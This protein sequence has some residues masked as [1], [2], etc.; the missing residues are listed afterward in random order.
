M[1]PLAINF[2]L[3]NKYDEEENNN[4]ECFCCDIC[5]QSIN[6]A[7]STEEDTNNSS[8]ILLLANGKIIHEKCTENGQ[9][10]TQIF[11][12]CYP[13]RISQLLKL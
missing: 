6:D 11:P 1:K 2:E 12:K 13:E 4:N 10:P 5:N 3:L 8:N 9:P 7:N